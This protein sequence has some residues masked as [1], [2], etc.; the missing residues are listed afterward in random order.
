MNF[1]KRQTVN[2]VYYLELLERLRGKE[3]NNPKI[4]AT[5]HDSWTTKMHLLTRHWLRGEGLA[6]KQ[7]TVLEH[8]A[9]SPD[10]APSDFFLVSKLKQ[11]WK[12]RHFDD[13]DDFRNNTMAALKVISR[14]KFQNNLKGGLGADI[15]VL[16]PMG[17]T[18]N[19]TTVV[20]S[21]ELCSNLPRWV[22]ELLLIIHVVQAGRY[23]ATNAHGCFRK[24][25]LFREC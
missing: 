18:L 6:T 25:Q 11:I 23:F 4:L 10:Q 21:N 9:Y 2:Q 14:N 1:T 3:G 5:T 15:V 19:A 8:P 12:G 22:R 24:L 13:I 20:F 7:I 16:L 17:S